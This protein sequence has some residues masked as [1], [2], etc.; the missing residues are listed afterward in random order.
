MDISNKV[1]EI[2]E[3]KGG[4]VVTVRGNLGNHNYHNERHVFTERSLMTDFVV[5]KV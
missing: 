3:V 5:E 2:E 4:W 1:I